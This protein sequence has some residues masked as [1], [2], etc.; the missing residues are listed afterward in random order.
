MA[1]Q[2]HTELEDT[3]RTTL[4]IVVTGENLEID[5]LIDQLIDMAQEFANE[6]YYEEAVE[7]LNNLAS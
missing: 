4:T 7:F 3:A 6:E 1:L 2:T 5:E